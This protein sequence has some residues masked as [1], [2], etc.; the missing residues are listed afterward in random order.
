[1]SNY[2]P[3][4]RQCQ[5]LLLLIGENPLPNWV[6][7]R[8]LVRNGGTVYLFHS[9]GTK[10]HARR[11]KEILER[12][13]AEEK[14]DIQVKLTEIKESDAPDI[15][16][17]VL[18][19]LGRLQNEDVGLHYT[20]G[21]KMMSVHAHRALW[22]AIKGKEPPAKSHISYLDART[23]QM[24]FELPVP[25]DKFP[26][27]Q[28]DEVRIGLDTLLRLHEQYP[29]SPILYQDNEGIRCLEAASFLAKIHGLKCG[30]SAWRSWCDEELQPL[31]DARRNQAT[32][33]QIEGITLPSLDKFKSLVS[34]SKPP[35]RES[36]IS[37]V[38]SLYQQFLSALQYASMDDL[39]S[40]ADR[41]GFKNA[42]ELARWFHGTWLEHYTLGQVCASNYKSQL[43]P[44]GIGMNLNPK[45]ANGGDLFE[46]DVLAIK[47]YQ[48]FYFSCYSGSVR[49]RAKLKLFEAIARARQI[50]GDEARVSLVSFVD[51]PES[52][53]NE[54]KSD[55]RGLDRVL[56]FGRS[57]VP[58][59]K[60]R[61]DEWFRS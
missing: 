30:E 60:S 13:W 27:A 54:V 6:A 53:L 19:E 16:N 23:M 11:L 51:D 9:N 2:I 42:R 7:A 36:D 20:G 10:P 29:D 3:A 47:G 4:D 26:V 37:T 24:K 38:V 58:D 12:S 39:K 34:E 52:L 32:L 5:H 28:A 22:D 55:W 50:G 43:N 17:A 61:L 59:L 48:L 18:D 40:I 15:Y 33:A 41:E 44:D 25:S 21:T 57:E 8:L 45:G 35:P 1:M 56:V 14:K 46:V 49:T 31:L